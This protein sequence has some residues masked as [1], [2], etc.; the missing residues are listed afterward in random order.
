MRM[1]PGKKKNQTTT[2]IRYPTDLHL[3]NDARKK[4]EELIDFL[5]IPAMVI[6]KPRTD[7]KH[8]ISFFV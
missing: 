6:K 7:R 3:L 1:L 2:D 8:E 4:T 5:H